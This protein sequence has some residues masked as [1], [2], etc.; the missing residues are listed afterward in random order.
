MQVATISSP[1]IGAN[2]DV[3]SI[4]SQ[5]MAVER[6]P[7]TALD[8]KET[9]TKAKLSALGTLKSALVTL[10]KAAQGLNLSSDFSTL[11][12]NVADTSALT[13][14]VSGA[15]VPGTYNIE[16]KNL[17]QAQKLISADPGYATTDTVV[18]MGTLTLASGTYTDPTTFVANSATAPKTI[19][20]D[21]TNNTLTGIRDAI[22]NAGAGVN[23]TIINNGSGN[24]L[25]LT[26][27]NT[28]AS[29]ALN[30]TATEDGPVGLSQLVYDPT[31]PGASHLTQ[32]VVAK[33]AVVKIDG[34]TST[35]PSNTIT[36]AIQGVTL[37]LSKAMTA[38]TTTQLTLTRDTSTVHASIDTFVKAYNDLTQQIT[39]ATAY[40]STNGG[41]LLTGDATV[42]TI[43][44][45]LRSTLSNAISGAQD[46][47]TTLSSAGI[48][49]QK[50]GTLL[51]DSTKLDTILADPNKNLAKLFASNDNGPGYASQ[52]NTLV[53]SF[54]FGDG[55]VLSSRINSINTAIASIDKQRTDINN[56][57]VDVEKRYNAQFTALDVAISNMTQTS[58]FL[59]KQLASLTTTTSA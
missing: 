7:V 53:N 50:D 22:N 28:G 29:N 33:D 24:Y 14:G 57:L 52:I 41:S 25:S 11:K 36:D 49:F 54:T 10:Q 58:N 59:T 12:A 45:Q 19:T 44:A 47:L 56:R 21:S 34:I 48:S 35:K 37:N 2:L 39:T 5:L 31:T 40:D 16:V 46:G 43:Q 55:G 3:K 6:Q 51:V 15:T 4:V 26:S 32:N 23:A 27:T 18:G 9:T 1:G 30:I 8:T 20:I 42:R 13:A 38:D 17:A